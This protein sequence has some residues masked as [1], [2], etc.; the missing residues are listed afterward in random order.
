M[1]NSDIPDIITES[2]VINKMLEFDDITEKD[3]SDTILYPISWTDST[4]GA[5]LYVYYRNGI[6]FKYHRPTFDLFNALYSIEKELKRRNN[7]DKMLRAMY[8]NYENYHKPV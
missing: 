2:S 1:K 7:N 8:I 3:I 5:Y 4:L 6:K